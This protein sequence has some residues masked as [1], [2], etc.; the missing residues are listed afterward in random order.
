[1][2]QWARQN[3]EEARIAA[4]RADLRMEVHRHNEENGNDLCVRCGEYTKIFKL[5]GLYKADDSG[6]YC[7]K[8]F[9]LEPV[10]E[11]I[12]KANNP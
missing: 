5:D 3:P 7:I 6:P 1:M 11:A 10:I 8:C 9:N 2:S 4:R 12:E